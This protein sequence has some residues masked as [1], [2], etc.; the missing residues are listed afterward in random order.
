[1]YLAAA[2]KGNAAIVAFGK[3]ANSWPSSET[4]AQAEVSAQ[5]AIAA[6]KQF[7]TILTDYNWPSSATA[8]VHAL[9]SA[10][11]AV[12]GDL[13]GL[14]SVDLFSSSNWAQQF[15]HDASVTGTDADLVRHDLGLKASSS[16]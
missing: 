10:M 2:T 8:D 15:T 12:T 5:P 14:S 13:E 6:L 4:G 1:V 16:G 11:G 9:I 7:T 3:A